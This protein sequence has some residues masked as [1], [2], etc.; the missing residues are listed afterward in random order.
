MLPE[1]EYSLYVIQPK[2]ISLT[3]PFLIQIS[4]EHDAAIEVER[5]LRGL[6]SRVETVRALLGEGLYRATV[7]RRTGKKVEIETQE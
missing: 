1:W 4:V 3:K 2:P 5:K 7:R 6:K